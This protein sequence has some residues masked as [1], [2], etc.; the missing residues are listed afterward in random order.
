MGDTAHHKIGSE[1][2]HVSHQE[3][4]VDA[5]THDPISS[6]YLCRLGRK[7]IDI[8]TQ[9][10]ASLIV[11]I[12]ETYAEACRLILAC[13][14]RVILIGM[15]K[16]GHIARKIAATLASTG[17]ASY[18]VHPAE[19]GHGD[20]GMLTPGDVVLSI[21][22]S[23]ETEEILTL[24][25]IIKLLD[26]PIIAMTGNPQSTLANYATIHLDISVDK[27][28]CPLGLAPTSSTTAALVMGD[29]IAITLLEARGFKANDF[30]RYHPGGSLGRR[31]LLRI[32]GLMHTGDNL[33]RV[34]EDC[35]LSEAL[36][37]ITQKNLGMTTVVDN[38][39]KLCGIFT[40]GDLRRSLDQNLDIHKTPIREIMS[41]KCV[42]IAKH[43]LAAEALQIMEQYKITSLV[44][45]EDEKPIG[46][47]HMHALLRAG[48]C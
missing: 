43:N 11:R 36:L 38:Q 23:G 32:E 28:A 44:V 33:P 7:V 31:L 24:L 17:T 22:N 47:I 21:S 18:F 5:N 8:E 25:P 34:K 48:I 9:S 14:G 15:G 20:L 10:V 46:V 35:L 30:A 29:A 42:T 13:K 40:D 19:A 27:E 6:E 3:I 41:K 16:S 12:N 45:I 39:N 1:F 2:V 37:E 4:R 26:I